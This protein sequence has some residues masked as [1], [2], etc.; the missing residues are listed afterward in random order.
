V[1]DRGPL[2]SAALTAWGAVALEPQHRTTS[3]TL[4]PALSPTWDRPAALR[5]QVARARDGD[6][7]WDRPPCQRKY[8]KVERQ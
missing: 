5:V 8:E 2:P 3:Q 4:M 6:P 1:V 7:P